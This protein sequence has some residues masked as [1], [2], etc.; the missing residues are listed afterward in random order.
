MVKYT[1]FILPVLAFFIIL[2]ISGCESGSTVATGSAVIKGRVIDSASS[3]QITGAAITTLPATSNV[4]SDSLGNFIISDLTAGTYTVTAK[5]QG[6]YSRSYTFDIADGDTLALTMKMY[7][8][9]IF[10]YGPFVV[11]EYFD[12]NSYSGVNVYQGYSVKESD[13]ANKDIQLRDS[14][15]TSYNF[16]FRSGDLALR[17]AGF[18]TKFTSDPI[19]NPQTNLPD[20]SQAQFDSLA[21]IYGGKTLTSSDFPN[22]RIPY[23]NAPLVD[24]FVFGVYLKGRNFFNPTYALVYVNNAYFDGNNIFHCVLYIKTNRYGINLFKVNT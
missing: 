23:F 22:D 11:D 21:T 24:R 1:K 2:S 5:K 6:Y 19:L 15:G 17:L 10:S 18:E 20:F 14:N 13:N 16:Y 7:Y 4:T 8:T 12:D 3:V 9:N